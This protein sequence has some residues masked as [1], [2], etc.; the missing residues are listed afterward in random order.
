MPVTPQPRK[1]RNTIIGT[2]QTMSFTSTSVAN[3]AITESSEPILQS[4]RKRKKYDF[5]LLQRKTDAKY[6]KKSE[7][8][9]KSACGEKCV[10]K[11]SS[12]FGQEDR[13]AIN[14]SYWNFSWQEQHSFVRAHS[15]TVV[16]KKRRTNELDNTKVEVCKI[17]LLTTLDYEK[18][19]DRIL[20][21]DFT[22]GSIDKRGKHQ[23]TPS[24]ERDTLTQH[25]ESFNP[26]NHHYRRE[27]AP[28]RRYLPSDIS[29]VQMHKHFCDTYPNKKVSY[30]LHREH[31]KKMNISFT[32][33]GNEECET[34]ESYNLLKNE[35]S[36][37]VNKQIIL[38]CSECVEWDKHH[39]KYKKARELYHEHKKNINNITQINILARILKR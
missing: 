20:H 39:K 11:C 18:T 1:R 27:H 15:A 9:V 38:G 2:Y 35:T 19:N 5:T 24:I 37:D 7:N 16:P 17:F 10:N 34:C 30:E 4:Q 21:N 6:K 33:L 31:M 25:V 29:I 36:H 22:D 26:L 14:T 12:H 28:F 13:I 8:N 3:V 23:K 32:R